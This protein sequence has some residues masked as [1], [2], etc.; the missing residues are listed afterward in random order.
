ML[1]QIKSAKKLKEYIRVGL[2]HLNA[3]KYQIFEDEV[4]KTPFEKHVFI[5]YLLGV[6][7]LN[8]N[9]FIKK[10][11]INNISMFFRL[12]STVIFK[13]FYFFYSGDLPPAKN[14]KTLNAEFE[15]FRLFY[16]NVVWKSFHNND[17]AYD[18]DSNH[19]PRDINWPTVPQ[20]IMGLYRS[21]S[22]AQMVNLIKQSKKVRK[23]SSVDLPYLNPENYQIFEEK[24][25][26]TPFEKHA[27]ISHF[28]DIKKTSYK[29]LMQLY[30][31]SY[32]KF[33]RL[34]DLIQYKLFYF[35]HSGQLPPSEDFQTYTHYLRFLKS[36]YEKQSN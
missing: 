35:F 16:E 25:L 15:F 36:Y 28:L 21:Y 20:E 12:Y 24:V 34:T 31:V 19:Q 18:A 30:Q 11:Q 5:S 32:A 6:D 2:P 14:Y 23:F 7:N 29:E 33:Y 10:Y 4:L 3:E 17:T 9:D 27:F 22:L 1:E 13:F 8:Q 26:I